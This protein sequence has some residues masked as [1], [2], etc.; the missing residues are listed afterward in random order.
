MDN[1]VGKLGLLCEPKNRIGL[2][3]SSY[4]IGII[5]SMLFV[6]ALSDH[7]GR[8]KIFCGTM[9][10]SIIG[11][12]GLIYSHSLTVSTCFMVVLGMTWPGKRVTGIN[13]ILEFIPESN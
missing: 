7:I 9:V 10:V 11:Q 3:G 13:Y 4:F 12:I 1:W 5:A 6:P 8:K 2:L